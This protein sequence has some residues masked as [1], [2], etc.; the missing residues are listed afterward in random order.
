MLRA[1][2]RGAE[3]DSR[4]LIVERLIAPDAPEATVSDLNM[5]VL[6]GGL[7]RTREEFESLLERSGFSL[8]RVVAT[9]GPFHLLVC[10]AS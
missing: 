5:L 9:R 10:V 6:Q 7:E 1:C 8:Q 4:L 3:L 2:R